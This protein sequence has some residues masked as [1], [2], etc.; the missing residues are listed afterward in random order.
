MD[1]F[2]ETLTK[3]G[4]LADALVPQLDNAGVMSLIA[5]KTSLIER[6]RVLRR[7]LLRQRRLAESDLNRCN[8]FV[9]R[10]DQIE[11]FLASADSELSKP[12][13]LD[14]TDEMKLIQKLGDV[15]KIVSSFSQLQPVN[16]ELNDFGYRLSLHD[17]ESSRLGKINRQWNDSVAKTTDLRD[18]LQHQLLLRQSFADKCREWKQFLENVENDLAND[19][20]G[21]Y[22]AL[23]EQQCKYEVRPY[24]GNLDVKF[25]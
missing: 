7:T 1:K 9:Q 18:S 17:D 12:T 10:C 5:D 3:L 23:L 14:S 13:I 2:D 4:K 22:P 21:N 24:R 11:E 15:K 6:T 8:Q 25:T 19:P 20:W 16:S